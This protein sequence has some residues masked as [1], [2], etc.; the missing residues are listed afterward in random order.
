M[1]ELQFRFRLAVYLAWLGISVL[2]L[3]L[4][5]LQV[6]HGSYY[7]NKSEN[8]RTRSIRVEAPRG[9]IYDRF[10]KVI[11]RN[12]PA[13]NLAILTEDIKDVNQTLEKIAEI[14][15]L[16]SAELIN[17]FKDSSKNYRRF[18][19][20]VA[21][22]DISHEDLARIEARGHSLPGVITTVEPAR[23]Y[24]Y[25]NFASQL[26]GYTREISPEQLKQYKLREEGKEKYR[27]GDQAGQSGLE[28]SRE[29]TLKGSPGYLQ[30]EVDARGRR[31][32]ELGV[33]DITPGKD[34]YLTID[35]ELQKVA[36]EQMQG[37]RGAIVAIEPNTGEILALVSAP[38]YDPNLFSGNISKQDWKA[39]VDHPGKPFRNRAVSSAYPPGS[40]SK[41]LWATAGLEKGIITKNTLYN[42]PGYYK[43]KKRRFHCHK[44][45]GHG[46][47]NVSKAIKVSCNAFF[48]QLGHK[49]GIDTLSEYLEKFGFGQKTGIDLLAEKT[50]TAPS[51]EWKRKRFKE[52]WYDGDTIPVSIG[53]GYFTTTPLQLTSMLSTLVN[54]GKKFKPHLLKKIIRGQ[55]VEYVNAKI[56]MEMNLNPENVDTVKMAARSVV[57]EDGGTGKR[58]RVEGVEI[59]GKTGTAQVAA[60]EHGIEGKLNDHAWFISFAPVDRPSIVLSV[61]V[62]NGGHGG[63]SAAPIA[64]A[65]LQKYFVD[66]GVVKE[67][68]VEE[69]KSELE[70][71]ELAK[72]EVNRN[73]V[74]TQ[75]DLN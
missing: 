73:L 61:I 43:I 67:P 54:G 74:V 40:T 11:V 14:L 30:V 55:D 52:K 41:L 26:L 36:E 24:P 25:D 34:V 48:Y 51:R 45:S 50:A 22:H 56:L 42:C 23:V 7:R 63:E 66:R 59:G 20:Q 68:K 15:K 58:A 16:D 39:L 18:E 49:L 57:E 64:Q 29:Q 8:N 12:R 10:G 19:P 71:P 1:K 31:R 38:G 21:I 6:V 35:L 72:L 62:E 32:A 53:Q 46:R 44:R 9:I 3:R 75:R 47:V 37:K 60:L 5:F 69:E 27:P 4:W 33:V 28:L 2:L 65:I 17:N 13:F 70:E